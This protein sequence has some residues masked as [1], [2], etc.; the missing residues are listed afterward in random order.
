MKTKVLSMFAILLVAGVISCSPDEFTLDGLP[1]QGPVVAGFNV[2]GL[3][4]AGV[5]TDV[6]ATVNGTTTNPVSEVTFQVFKKG[7]EDMVREFTV[8]PTTTTG[9]VVVTWTATDSDLST[10]EAGD[11]MLR[12]IGSN[13]A[14]KTVSQ[15]YFTVPDYVVPQ[16]CQVVGQVTVIMLT[17][18]PL[19]VSEVVSAI[20]SFTGSGWGTDANMIRIKQGVYCVALPLT[21]GDQF[22]FRLNASWGTQEKKDNCNDGDNRSAPG[23]SWPSISIQNVPKWGGYGC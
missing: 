22:K 17:P 18:Q 11:Y 23:G 4:F 10:L 3:L 13:S 2:P 6:S 1:K 14:G 20:G 5:P 7:T 9:V 19:A 21:G 16:A 8:T 12:A 15:T